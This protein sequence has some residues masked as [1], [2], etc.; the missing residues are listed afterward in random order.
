MTS[1]SVK[2]GVSSDQIKEDELLLEFI[3]AHRDLVDKEVYDRLLKN[4]DGVIMDALNQIHWRSLRNREVKD[5][6]GLPEQVGGKKSFAKI[7]KDLSKGEKA[8]QGGN[9][10]DIILP[11]KRD[12]WNNRFGFVKTVSEQEAGFII[13]NLK[14]YKGLGRILKMSINEKR[15][16]AMD[17]NFEGFQNKIDSMKSGVFDKRPVNPM[18]HARNVF[19]YME[20]ETNGDIEASILT[21]IVGYTSMERS[22]DDVLDSMKTEG[23]K[24]VRI[25]QV[26]NFTFYVNKVDNGVWQEEECEVLKKIFR[27]TRKFQ[28]EDFVIPRVVEVK[29]CGIPM[30]AW[31]EEN[32]KAYTKGTKG[33]FA[34]RVSGCRWIFCRGERIFP[35]DDRRIR[36][37]G[38]SSQSVSI[39]ANGEVKV[40]D[41]V[42][43]NN[44]ETTKIQKL[45]VNVSIGFEPGREDRLD[46]SIGETVVPE[47]EVLKDSEAQNLG[48][49]E[50]VN[51]GC[52]NYRDFSE[53]VISAS[54]PTEVNGGQV[55]L[56]DDTVQ[57]LEEENVFS[58]NSICDNMVKINM[59]VGR[60]RPRKKIIAGLGRNRKAA[61]IV[62]TALDMGLTI[63]GGREEGIKIIA[64]RI[65]ENQETKCS[66]WNS[67]AIT[68]LCNKQDFEWAEV[69]ARGLSGG[70]LCMWDKS[71]YSLIGVC[72]EENW[73]WC[74]LQSREDNELF[75]VINVYSAQDLESKRRLWLELAGIVVRH[76]NESLCIIGD[77]NSIRDEAER[78][79]CLY[80]RDDT[81][82][83]N[84][85]IDNSNLLE[86]N[87]GNS[88]FT[89]RKSD[90]RPLF[91]CQQ[92]QNWGPVPF[93]IFNYWLKDGGLVADVESQ[94]CKDIQE[95]NLDVLSILRRARTKIKEWSKL[96]KNNIDIQIKEVESSLE[97]A[98]NA[99]NQNINKVVLNELLGELYEQKV[100]MLRQKA[101]VN[102]QVKGDRNTKFFHQSIQKRRCRNL[103]R[104]IFWKQA[105]ISSP[106]AL[107]EAFFEYFSAL[108]DGSR[109]FIMFK[110]GS[111][112][113]GKI[114]HQESQ[115]LD[116]EIKMEEVEGVL[117]HMSLEKA[118]GPD[119]FNLGSINQLW[120]SLKG[121]IMQCFEKFSSKGVFPKGLNSSFIAL[122][123]KV[124]QPKLVIDYRPISLINSIPK[125]FTRILA[126][127]LGGKWWFNWVA[128][129]EFSWAS[130]VRS[131]YNCSFSDDLGQARSNKHPSSMLSGIVSI[132]TED[133]FSNALNGSNFRWIVK[134]GTSVLFWEDN[135]LESG[136]LYL[137]FARL[138]QLSKLKNTTAWEVDEALR[139]ND[140]V[141]CIVFT[142]GTDQLI[143]LKS[144]K[145]YLSSDGRRLLSN[146]S[147]PG[148]RRLT[149]VVAD[150]VCLFCNNGLEEIEHLLWSCGYSKKVWKEVLEWWGLSNKW[151]SAQRYNF[152]E[153][154]NWFDDRKMKEAWAIVIAPTLWSLWLNRN[155]KMFQSLHYKEEDV[156][157]LIKLRAQKWCQAIESLQDDYVRLWPVHPMGAISGS[158]RAD[159]RDV[160][161]K[162]FNFIGY[163]DGS[164][165]LENDGSFSAGI[166]GYLKGMEGNLVYIFSGPVETL[167][168]M[169]AEL[170]A[171]IHLVRAVSGRS[172]EE[173]SSTRMV[174]KE[175]CYRGWVGMWLEC[176]VVV[177]KGL[178]IWSFDRG[179][180]PVEV[181][182]IAELEGDF[183][184][185]LVVGEVAE[186]VDGR[187]EEIVV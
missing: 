149:N 12:R 123:P 186:E 65:E 124:A 146:G 25:L 34:F 73:L 156:F 63:V 107:K 187:L 166:G 78:A 28:E 173:L 147:H 170:Y 85:F 100:D 176:I 44:K 86:L 21:S 1:K 141:D 87:M 161:D 67:Q 120:D 55:S 129:R 9:I 172:Y 62:D 145:T 68:N 24:D 37:E 178:E 82:G 177:K 114:T 113:L 35:V 128:N 157:F 36:E 139:L 53:T 41:S 118:P 5:G 79:N 46:L 38:S 81:I 102:W 15:G 168:S 91:L 3:G 94:I 20:S 16:K 10:K 162:D 52:W 135:W 39:E 154:I 8:G 70:L 4:E 111:F 61:K 133:G 88:E 18:I 71:L 103:I 50:N 140:I 90:H 155:L 56:E 179:L 42:A 150:M 117:K 58:Q 22:D 183:T 110:L 185:E 74:K 142:R 163:S 164:V 122:I 47:S 143:W 26:N 83:F 95:G 89:W 126:E 101:R 174:L 160:V 137:S 27:K 66:G 11:R 116:R 84:H 109:E 175:G 130:L 29:C 75:S 119:G 96:G 32:L 106:T 23:L 33:G 51:I 49:S 69:E 115:W 144:G 171:V 6:K 45:G 48:E 59:G 167:S 121:K 148:Y 93:K 153:W 14:Q 136:V 72:K 98:D 76:Q 80:R 43:D 30:L 151:N 159:R 92:I 125:L 169:L 17:L 127:R 64:R 7:V 31:V 131:K 104:K 105:W 99:S 181:H 182:F 97:Q 57:A 13:S 40:Q 112:Q 180:G 132:N 54:R 152:W 134:D 158:V 19:E 138:Y 184:G 60:G 77:F 165:K 108:F 2:K